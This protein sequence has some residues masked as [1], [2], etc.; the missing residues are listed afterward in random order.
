[1]KKALTLLMIIGMTFFGLQGVKA[2]EVLTASE[3][4]ISIFPN[5]VQENL[6]IEFKSDRHNKIQ[7]SLSDI[8]GKIIFNQTYETHIGLNKI[9]RNI[10]NIP[11][12]IYFVTVI[13]GDFKRSM[14][15]VKR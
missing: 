2:Q 6:S 15:I 11:K 14:K 10:S 3:I 9:N 8:L 5:P 4:K 12:G 1:M 13:S 7:I